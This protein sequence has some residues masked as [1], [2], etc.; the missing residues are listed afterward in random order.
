MGITALLLTV[1]ALLCAAAPA[2]AGPADELPLGPRS[3]D[4]RRTTS[5]VAP[6]V[7]WTRIV[8]GSARRR[9]GPWRVHVLRVAPGTSAGALLSNGVVAGV[10]RPSVFGSTA[11]AGVNG[12]YYVASG[13]GA[14]DVVGTSVAGGELASEPVDGR[15]VLL[16]PSDPLARPRVAALSFDGSV[17]I[18]GATRAL[19]GVNR[20]RGVIW[21]CGGRGGDRPTERPVHGIACT[22][23]SELVHMTPLWGPRT[24]PLTGGVE[25]TVRDDVVTG[26]ARA[27]G[28]TPIPRDG[29]VL[30]G[31]GDAAEL[32]RSALPGQAVRVSTALRTSSGSPLLLADLNGAVSGGPRLLDSGRIALRTKA[33]GFGA[34]GLYARF[35]LGAHPRTLAGVTATGDLL[36]VTVDGRRPGWS[37][38]VSLR[39]AARVMKA[40]GARDALNLDGGGSTAMVVRGRVVNRPSDPGGERPVGDGVFVGAGVR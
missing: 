38:G 8:R 31:S 24:P 36:L 28:G 9:P 25:L 26:A 13:L 6:G 1:T 4:E 2:A 32:L 22:D 23:P 34:P 39:D 37:T 17:T 29:Y 33:E 18:G 35:V 11:P 20:L 15:S 40:L 5:D 19:D 14:G 21:G 10:E 27:G 12:A 3:L 7:T 30:S 16:L